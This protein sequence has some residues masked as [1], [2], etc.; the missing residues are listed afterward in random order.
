MKE[1]LSKLKNDKIK[2][3]WN[4]NPIKM[5][6]FLSFLTVEVEK[7]ERHLG[8][9]NGW[10]RYHGKD[11]LVI[12]GG[13][14]NKVEYLDTLKYKRKLDNPW[15]DFVNPFYLFDIMTQEGKDFFLDYYKD[16]IED[17]I[18]SANSAYERAKRHKTDVNTFWVYFGKEDK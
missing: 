1:F 14:V 3:N 8:W 10:T 17:Q 4:K 18:K 7:S 11:D 9:D 16:E 5:A 15:N 2:I 6:D 13:V 12:G